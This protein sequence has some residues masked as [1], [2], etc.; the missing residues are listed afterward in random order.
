MRV[1]GFIA[2]IILLYTKNNV[3]VTKN[4]IWHLEILIWL[5]IFAHLGQIIKMV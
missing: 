5:Y 3:Y 1:H 4:F 2:F